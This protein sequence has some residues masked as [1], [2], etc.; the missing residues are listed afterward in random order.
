MYERELRRARRRPLVDP[1]APGPRLDARGQTLREL[2]PHREPFLLLDS[3]D[4]FDP[5]TRVAT[6]TRTIDAADP[7]FAG[8]FPGGPVYPGVLL[9]EMM[10]QLG[11]CLA[12]LLR[13]HE[14]AQ[15][16]PKLRLIKIS[17]AV[18]PAAVGP[19]D[20]VTLLAKMLEP[21]DYVLPCL[22]QVWG[23]GEV[24]AAALIEVMIL[25]HTP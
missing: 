3:V 12:T 17:E 6:G 8:H 10:G 14:S 2:L 5:E 19:G 9:V 18:F 23:D 22:G 16:S 20:A 13:R 24:K 7:V 15:A 4:S 1:G 21:G 25:D 11:V